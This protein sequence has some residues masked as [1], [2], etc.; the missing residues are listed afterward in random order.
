MSTKYIAKQPDSHGFIPYT[1][2]EDETWKILFERQIKIVEPR[3]CQDFLDGLDALNMPRDRIPQCADINKRLNQLTGWSVE[4]VAALISQTKFFTMLAEKKFPAASFIRLREELDYL[5]EPDIFHEL[6]GHC[7]LLTNQAYADFVEW[8]GKNALKADKPAQKLLARLFWFTIEFGLL[9]NSQG[10]FSVYGG[11]ILSSKEETVYAVESDIP[12]RVPFDPLTCLRTPYR[13]DIIQPLYF[14][15]DKL[16]DLYHLCEKNLVS[17]AELAK[18]EG[19][20]E[21]GFNVC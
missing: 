21:P 20:T 15:L 10:K 19:D 4:P 11:G 3:A 18:V 7:P 5:Q 12:E 2:E 8:Y 14:Y 1:E 9:K 17:L 16:E 6:F 13:Y